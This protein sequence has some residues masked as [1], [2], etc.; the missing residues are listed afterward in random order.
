MA[1]VRLLS[2]DDFFDKLRFWFNDLDK[3]ITW[4]QVQYT[5]GKIIGMLD[6]AS[7]VGIITI[8][9]WKILF[10]MTAEKVNSII[11]KGVI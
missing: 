10:R 1:T 3:S 4:P 7:D 11:E 6:V 5:H 2:T 8:N 9:T